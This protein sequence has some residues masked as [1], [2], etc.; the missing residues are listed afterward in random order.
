MRQFQIRFLPRSWAL[1]LVAAYN[2]NG[3]EAFFTVGFLCFHAQL[4]FLSDTPWLTDW[5]GRPIDTSGLW[6]TNP[7][8]AEIPIPSPNYRST[9]SYG[10]IR[11]GVR[12][13]AHVE[14]YKTAY[15]LGV[16]YEA[17]C[18]TCDERIR[19]TPASHPTP[20]GSES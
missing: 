7:P 3:A 20:A 10:P 9:L 14:F 18:R 4:R 2:T 19:W 12:P 15:A 1:P 16:S 6:V 5:R 13:C 17:N 8:A 11:R